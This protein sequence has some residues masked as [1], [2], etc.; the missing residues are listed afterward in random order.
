MLGSL[1]F[2][3]DVP[4]YG[5]YDNGGGQNGFWVHILTYW[6][7][8]L[9]EDVLFTVFGSWSIGNCEIKMGKI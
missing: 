4:V 6:V 7:I 1:D 5:Q 2:F 8:L 9:R 3:H